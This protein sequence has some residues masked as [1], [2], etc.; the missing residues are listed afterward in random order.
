MERASGEG[1]KRST[2]ATV[3]KVAIATIVT[4]QDGAVASGDAAV[5]AKLKEKRP[6][7]FAGD[8]ASQREQCRGRGVEPGSCGYNK[9]FPVIPSLLVVEDDVG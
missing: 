3:A 1:C 7:R 2:T 9:L 6:L 8:Q 4:K 5:V